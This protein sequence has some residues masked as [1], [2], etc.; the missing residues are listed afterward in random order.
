MAFQS[1]VNMEWDLL[2]FDVE[3]YE[4]VSE[5][6][7]RPRRAHRLC[8]WPFPCDSEPERDCGGDCPHEHSCAVDGGERNRKRSLRAPDSPA[9]QALPYATQE[10]ELPGAGTGRI[11]RTA[12][13]RFEREW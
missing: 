1:A 5:S 10:V 13:V 12:E 4:H 11:P 3:N 6:R 2:L 8:L 7:R 9:F